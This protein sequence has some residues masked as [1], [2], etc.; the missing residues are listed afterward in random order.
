MI[1]GAGDD[2][3]WGQLAAL[4]KVRHKAGAVR[5]FKVGA[6]AAQ[7]FGKQEVARLRM[8]QRG[9]V[10]LIKFQI[11]HP[12]ARPPGHRDTVSGRDVGVSGVLINLGGSAGGEHHRLRAAGFHALFI[13]VPD[14]RSDHPA[15]AW[16]ANLIRY[17][18]VDGIAALKDADIGVGEGF[19]DQRRL[20]RFAGSVG[21]VENAPMA[22]APFAREMIALF[23]IGLDLSVKQYA[24]IDKPLDA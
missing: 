4:V 10:K 24:L 22:V 5:A 9:G 15:R 11:R 23:A 16:Q 6:F 3:A 7:R 8:I 14:P 20:H 18:Q 19:I 2:I 12:A 17:D 1:D 13:A 21:G